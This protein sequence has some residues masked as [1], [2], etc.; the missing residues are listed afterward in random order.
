[1]AY[2]PSPTSPLTG[3]R[4]PTPV[5]QPK[6]KREKRRDQHNVLQ[7]DMQK[8]FSNNREQHYRAQLIALQHDMNFVTTADPYGPE[9]LEDSPDEIDRMIQIN[10]SGTPFQSEMSSLAGKWYSE[11]VGEVNEA[12]ESKEIELIQLAVCPSYYSNRR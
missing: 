5:A 12:K 11:F 8:E 3:R 1:M 4:S 9:P 6:T 7:Q 10:A 2:S